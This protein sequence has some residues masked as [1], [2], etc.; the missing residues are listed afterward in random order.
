MAMW[1]TVPNFTQC[2]MKHS[3]IVFSLTLLGQVDPGVGQISPQK[4]SNLCFETVALVMTKKGHEYLLVSTSKAN[5]Q[6]RRG[7]ALLILMGPCWCMSRLC[8]RALPSLS[9]TSLHSS[10]EKSS[11]QV[12]S[13]S[14]DYHFTYL[15][16]LKRDGHPLGLSVTG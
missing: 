5:S 12:F 2:R 3:G 4:T 14:C 8:P 10:S 7:C 9:P 1:V 16:N 15:N 11:A 6:E 13:S